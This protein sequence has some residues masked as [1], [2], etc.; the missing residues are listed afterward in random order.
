MEEADTVNPLYVFDLHVEPWSL[1][2]NFEC[3]YKL[4]DFMFPRKSK[5]FIGNSIY[6]PWDKSYFINFILE[7]SSGIWFLW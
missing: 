2:T 5:G 4:V 3:D 6:I 7:L 1:H